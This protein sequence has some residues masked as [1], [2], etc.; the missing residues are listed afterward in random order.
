MAIKTSYPELLRIHEDFKVRIFE[1]YPEDAT[2]VVSNIDLYAMFPQLWGSTALGFDEEVGG[3]AI[4]VGYTTIMY[5]E[6]CGAPVYGAYY[7]ERFAGILK[8]PNSLFFEDIQ[9]R[10][11]LSKSKLS[12]YENS[13]C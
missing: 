7:G 6:V 3:D 4:T 2:L 10:R 9:K 5:G 12:E 1:N 8:N 13:T 11:I